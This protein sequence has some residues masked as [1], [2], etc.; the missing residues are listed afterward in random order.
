[1]AATAANH[2]LAAARFFMERR[3]EVVMHPF[4]HRPAAAVSRG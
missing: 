3:G 4:Y 1:M 2:Q